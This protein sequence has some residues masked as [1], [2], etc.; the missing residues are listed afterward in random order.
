[1]R[2]L[3]VM[4]FISL[5]AFA[6]QKEK[7]VSVNV[8]VKDK[9]IAEGVYFGLMKMDTMLQMNAEGKASVVLPVDEPQYGIVKYK[10]KTKA[11]YLEPGK[12][13]DVIW[14]MRPSGLEIEFAGDGAD[15]NN[16]ING[17]ETR[18][19][20]MGD[21]GLKEDEFLEKIDQYIADNNK[22]LE[23]KGFDKVFQEKEKTRLLYDV[24]G[25]LWQYAQNRDC[26]EE[27]IAKMKSLMVEEDWLL[28]LD[29]YTNF[30]EGAVAYFAG[31]ALENQENASVKEKTLNVLNYV[32]SNIKS[33]A[34]KE[35]L[36]A[37][38]SIS[39]IDSEGVDDAEEVKAIFNKEVTNSVMQAAF[40]SLYA[41][42]SSVAKGSKA[43]GFKYLDINGKEV[44]LDDFKGRYV[45]IDIWATWCAPCREEYPHL[46]MLEKAFQGTN[47]S[48][49]SISTDQDE[50]KWKQTVKDEK[51]GGI[52][53][54][55][56]GDEDFLNAFRVKGIPR[57]I[58]IN[59]EGRIE[60]ANMT[61]PSDPMT[62]EYLGMLA[63][64][65]KNS[66]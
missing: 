16:F 38:F 7:S 31:K 14:D 11:I 8:T 5:L 23:S 24:C 62:I 44:S 47:I 46:Q 57:F 36:V 6:C 28:Q 40:N 10:W 64:R 45:Y 66:F 20:V 19:P 34:V 63:E 27:Y 33:Q 42:G 59:P 41:Q 2:K 37:S 51:M 17:K 29:S 21:F 30:M 55:T 9:N 25:I 26:S 1:M 13:L 32:L 3:V 48:F 52:Q 12:G 58:L 22:V 18:V 54:H 65:W 39:Y 49:V 15:K 43:H 60:N 50:A 53:L 61:R 35:Y 4:L 56:G